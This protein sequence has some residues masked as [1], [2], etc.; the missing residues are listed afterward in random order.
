MGRIKTALIKRT[1]LSLNKGFDGFS[2]NFVENK[3][4]LGDTMPS[5]SIRNKVAGYLAR[6]KRFEKKPIVVT[7]NESE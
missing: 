5:K 3:K 4:L 1:A 2:T 7:E 6:L